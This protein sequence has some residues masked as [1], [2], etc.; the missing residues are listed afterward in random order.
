[1][2][3]HHGKI[4]RFD[5]IIGIGHIIDDESGQKIPFSS[6][7]VNSLSIGFGFLTSGTKVLFDIENPRGDVT[8]AVNIFK[9]EK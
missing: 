2:S 5:P 9:I 7:S 8:E 6:T 1:M 4:G 3:K